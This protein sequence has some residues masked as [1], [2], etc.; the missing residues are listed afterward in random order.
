MYLDIHFQPCHIPP[1]LLSNMIHLLIPN[2]ETLRFGRKSCLGFKVGLDRN[3]WSFKSSFMNQ[4]MKSMKTCEYIALLLWNRLPEM[5]LINPKSDTLGG[6]T[7]FGIN[8]KSWP[9]YGWKM[10]RFHEGFTLSPTP[11]WFRW[12]SLR[13]RIEK[14]Q[15][16]QKSTCISVVFTGVC[17]LVFWVWGF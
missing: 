10:R 4:N 7:C 14:A 17:L 16:I 8:L 15:W 12:R 3:R 2:S 6:S 11:V 9:N 5:Y 1:P 13:H